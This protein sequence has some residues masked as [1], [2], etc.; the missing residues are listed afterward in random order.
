MFDT[1]QQNV[2]LH[3]RNVYSSGELDEASTHKEFLLVRRE[4]SRDVR[5]AVVHYNLD[6][7]IS[8]GYRVQSAT[9]T[10]FRR[11]ATDV[12]R[13]YLLEGVAVNERRL[14]ELGQV[15]SILSRSSDEL[16]AGVA[17][18]VAR[19]LPGLALLRDYDE[20]TITAEPGAVPG[21]TLTL[22]EA[23]AVVTRVATEFPDDG[24]FG[25]ERGDALD[26]VI[27][28]I[29]QSFGGWDLY[30]T[31]EEKGANLL[32]LVVKDHPLSDGN[33]RSAAALFVTFLAHNGLLLDADGRPDSEIDQEW[34]AFIAA[35]REAELDAIIADENLRP[36]ETRV[37][38]D[39]A[40]RDGHI[41]TSG[42]AITTVL[43]PVSRFSADRG[44]SEKK[45][46]VIQKLGAFFERFFALSP[47]G[48]GQPTS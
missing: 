23:R 45:Q 43:P 11:W 8:V 20:G 17:D 40:F 2:S 3:L 35:R 33:K 21:W 13:R 36:D 19:Y 32:Y 47:G 29:Y 37:F 44:H 34:G 39:A 27:G 10:R 31:V 26:G 6:A 48:T 16:I 14:Q 46:R 24:L 9:A 41:R 38:V 30:P 12:L 42:T 4:G 7:I 5:R 22:D 18:V 28:A 25:R 15:V 1:T